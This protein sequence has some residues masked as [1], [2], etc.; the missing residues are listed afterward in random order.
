MYRKP[1]LAEAAE[2]SGRTVGANDICAT[3][4]PASNM[5]PKGRD[6]REPSSVCPAAAIGVNYIFAARV[7]EKNHGR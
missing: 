6:A 4:A 1:W 7:P 5:A 3:P 2:V